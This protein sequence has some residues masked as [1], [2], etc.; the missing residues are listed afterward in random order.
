[1][2]HAYH[3]PFVLYH[4]PFPPALSFTPVSYLPPVP[5]FT[6]I[7]SFRLNQT[8]GYTELLA[9]HLSSH[10]NCYYSWFWPILR[11]ARPISL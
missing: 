2:H 4:L 1:M 5:Y 7:G 8:F 9:Y 10:P 11:P 3:L 6:S